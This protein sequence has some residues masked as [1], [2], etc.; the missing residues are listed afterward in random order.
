MNLGAVQARSTR[1][2][3]F[4]PADTST[5]VLRADEATLSVVAH[6]L[7]RSVTVVQ[8]GVETLRLRW[9]VLD[10]AS[11]EEIMQAVMDHA[12]LIGAS[13]QDL[14]RG[15]RCAEVPSTDDM[16]L[17]DQ[18]TPT[19]DLTSETAPVPDGGTRR[20][21]PHWV[22]TYAHCPRCRYRGV[23]V[24]AGRSL[25]RCRYCRAIADLTEDECAVAADHPE[26]F[27]ARLAAPTALASRGRA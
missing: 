20:T 26:R 15:M 25:I 12:V 27:I 2:G 10:D 5:W 16:A 8:G 4:P 11:R 9:D 13:L 18:A 17:W 22:P 21:R 7:L 6:G 19:V 14:V 3:Y 1:E 23:Y 24:V